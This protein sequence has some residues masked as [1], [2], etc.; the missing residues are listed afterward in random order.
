[1]YI[2]NVKKA[3]CDRLRGGYGTRVKLKA[4]RSLCI[5]VVI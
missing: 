5:N 4:L 2:R 1:M 3:K